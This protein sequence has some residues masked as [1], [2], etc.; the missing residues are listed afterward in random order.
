ME[1]CHSLI[2][3]CVCRFGSF[4]IIKVAD[5]KVA[6]ENTM[7]QFVS[8]FREVIMDTRF[9]EASIIHMEYNNALI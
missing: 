5:E 3:V 4:E 2:I 8:I 9:S 1:M 6:D 7:C